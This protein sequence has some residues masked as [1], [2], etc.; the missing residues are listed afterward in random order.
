[1]SKRARAAQTSM[2]SPRSYGFL[3]LQDVVMSCAVWASR[4]DVRCGSVGRP[5]C[6]SGPE[7][8]GEAL[9][10]RKIASF[11]RDAP[12]ARGIERALTD[13][14]LS[15]DTRERLLGQLAFVRNVQ[16]VR[17]CGSNGLLGRGDVRMSKTQNCALAAADCPP[18]ADNVRLRGEKLDNQARM[19]KDFPNSL[20][21]SAA[22][23]TISSKDLK[24]P[25]CTGFILIGGIVIWS[26][27]CR[28]PRPAPTPM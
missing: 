17:K 22:C 6:L 19:L 15:H 4:P 7:R 11:Q 13:E 28:F 10:P 21:A 24:K 25:P 23:A 3:L 2:R 12:W 27:H 18:V 1:M 20:T 5:H 26:I 16:N 8:K 14:I 9:S